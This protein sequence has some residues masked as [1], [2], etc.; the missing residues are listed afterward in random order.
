MA[1]KS[2]SPLSPFNPPGTM[3]VATSG[4]SRSLC[5]QRSSSS[6]RKGPPSQTRIDARRLGERPA[7]PQRGVVV[8]CTT[9]GTEKKKKELSAL[10]CTV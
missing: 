7:A 9:V 5:V 1:I 2:S 10:Y 6:I 3:S 4:V 8:Y